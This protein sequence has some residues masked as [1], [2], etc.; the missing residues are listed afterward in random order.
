MFDEALEHVDRANNL[1]MFDEA[2]EHVDQA[3]NLKMFDKSNRQLASVSAGRNGPRHSSRP[4][5]FEERQWWCSSACFGLLLR[6]DF[7]HEKS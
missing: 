5:F 6:R 3:N 4:E 7:P 2:M 1:E